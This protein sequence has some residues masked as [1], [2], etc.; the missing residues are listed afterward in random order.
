ML[1]FYY[2]LNAKKSEH[3]KEMVKKGV[4]WVDKMS[5]N[6]GPCRDA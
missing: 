5:T 4:D 6:K 2:S 1:G 3:V